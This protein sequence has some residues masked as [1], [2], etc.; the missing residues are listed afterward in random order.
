MILYD[1]EFYSN[2][3]LRESLNYQTSSIYESQI[4]FIKKDFEIRIIK[5]GANYNVDKTLRLQKGNKLYFELLDIHYDNF[6]TTGF[7]GYFNNGTIESIGNTNTNKIQINFK[8]NLIN[9]INLRADSSLINQLQFC[10][11]SRIDFKSSCSSAVGGT[12]GTSYTVNY[13]SQYM[14]FQIEQLNI[15]AVAWTD[16][17]QFI[18]GQ[19]TF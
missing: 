18:F 16:S 1:C 8:N 6:K 4:I 3:P 17:I 19:Y 10:W 14:K 12:G 7:K 2:V 9:Q 15:F 11:I 5:Y 13:D